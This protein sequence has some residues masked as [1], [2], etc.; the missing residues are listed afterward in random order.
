MSYGIFY[1]PYIRLKGKWLEKAGF[2]VGEPITVDVGF[3][4]LTI[5]NDNYAAH[6]LEDI[7]SGSEP[8]KPS[9][10]KRGYR[11]YTVSLYLEHD[12]NYEPLALNSPTEVYRFLEQLQYESR[13][14][15][16][17]IMLNAKNYVVGVYE[18]G[19]GNNTGL[20]AYPSEVIK[21]AI[22]TNSSALIMAHNHP[23]GI[24]EPSEHDVQITKR[25]TE[26]ARLM[27]I[28]VHDHIIIGFNNY[29]SL[30]E[31]GYLK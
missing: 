25:I 1:L 12:T 18:V 29:S 9:S 10:F 30:R 8:K 31:S 19:K 7:V 17:S 23:S 26:A 3:G 27:D 2:T 16:L 21:A 14:I 20:I 24:T 6:G 28:I 4:N 5:K 11:G 15:L 13:E 22:L